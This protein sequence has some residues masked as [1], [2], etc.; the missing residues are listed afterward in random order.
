[1]RAA[2]GRGVRLA[3]RVPMPAAAPAGAA[4]SDEALA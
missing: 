2:P 1:V 4:R 3:M